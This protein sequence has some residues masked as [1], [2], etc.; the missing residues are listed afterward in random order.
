[1]TTTDPY[2]T[3][4]REPGFLTN[5]QLEV[6]ELHLRNGMSLRSI[7]AYL[8][9]SLGTVRDH[10]KRASQKIEIRMRDNYFKENQP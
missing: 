2:W 6:L 9:V 1:M 5:R 3:I 4:A 8:D 10:I 7:A